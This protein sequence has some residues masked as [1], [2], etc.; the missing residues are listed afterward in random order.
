MEEGYIDAEWKKRMNNEDS[1]L[2][3]TLFL[4]GEETRDAVREE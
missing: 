3:F 2:D 4:P 1:R